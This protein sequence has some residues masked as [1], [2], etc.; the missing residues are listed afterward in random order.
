MCPVPIYK[1]AGDAA[2]SL[3][4]PPD[5][6]VDIS[7]RI[8]FKTPERLVNCGMKALKAKDKS[9]KRQCL[10]S[11]QVRIP[12]PSSSFFQLHLLDPFFFS[13]AI[14]PFLGDPIGKCCGKLCGFI[15]Q[16]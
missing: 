6:R 11:M 3:H 5:E 14:P 7:G 9:T 16:D 12:S 15:K 1:K 2:P 8:E 13:L 4:R 10:E